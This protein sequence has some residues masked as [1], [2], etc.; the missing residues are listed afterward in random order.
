M[1]KGHKE[2]CRNI[3]LSHTFDLRSKAPFGVNASPFLLNI[4]IKEH[5]SLNPT[6]EWLVLAKERF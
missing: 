1:V 4:V 2:T 5:L 6:N 3:Q